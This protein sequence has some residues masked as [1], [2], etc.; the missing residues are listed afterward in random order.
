MSTHLCFNDECRPNH[1]HYLLE[2]IHCLV[3]FYVGD[4]LFEGINPT[5]D[6]YIIRK[7]QMGQES[8]IFGESF[9][10]LLY[11]HH[12][13]ALREVS[14]KGVLIVLF[15]GTS[16]FSTRT[17]SEQIQRLTCFCF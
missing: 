6:S 11:S 8:S 12:S 2:S 15:L 5:F 17:V 9:Y 10:V 3:M 13:A 7:K 1:M 14:P 4:P 16:S